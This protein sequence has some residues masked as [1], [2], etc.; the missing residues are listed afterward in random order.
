MARLRVSTNRGMY[1]RTAENGH[2]IRIERGENVIETL[3]AFC[4]E[5]RIGSG[6]MHGIG[7]VHKAELG[8]Y[9]FEKREYFFSSL[10]EIHELV[11]MT[12]NIA[13]VDGEP[14]IHMHAVLGAGDETLSCVGGHVKEMEAAVTVEVQLTPYPEPVTRSYD[15]ETGLKLLDL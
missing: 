1:T 3:T 8:Y 4:K 2:L 12:G 13:L 11:S 5:H 6:V 7:A 15:E 9:D 10:P 14:F